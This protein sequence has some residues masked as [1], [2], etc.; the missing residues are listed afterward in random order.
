MSEI[1]VSLNENIAPLYAINGTLAPFKYTRENNRQ[2]T[3]NFTFYMNDRTML[4]NFVEGTQAR[5][6]ITMMN[7]RAAVQ[8]GYFNTFVIDIPQAKITAFKPGAQGPGEVSVSGT[9]RGTADANSFYAI[10]FTLVTT[11][12][13]GF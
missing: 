2:V 1:A 12:Q 10:Q 8:S 9:F 3:G 11:W 6:L 13:A 7:T 4:N 5:L